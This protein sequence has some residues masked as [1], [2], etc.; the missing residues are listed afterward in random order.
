[1]GRRV[2]LYIALDAVRLFGGS[3]VTSWVPLEMLLASPSCLVLFSPCFLV[4]A[5]GL[6]SYPWCSSE[7]RAYIGALRLLLRSRLHVRKQI[8]SRIVSYVF[9]EN[10][11]CFRQGASHWSGQC[12]FEMSPNVPKP[13]QHYRSKRVWIQGV[14]V[15]SS[16]E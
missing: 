8:C 14:F 9:P 2:F 10:P 1:V 3:F 16:I 13:F 6:L 15:I 5:C 7:G 12:D 11:F 4:L